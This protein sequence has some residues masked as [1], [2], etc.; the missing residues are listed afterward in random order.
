MPSPYI[1]DLFQGMVADGR[2]EP[3]VHYLEMASPDTYW[4]DCALPDYAEVLPG[5]WFGFMGS[6]IHVNPGAARRV[7]A[8]R[9]DVVV[10]AGYAGLTNQAVMARLRLHRQ[11][12]IFW[13]EISGMNRRRRLGQLLRWL[14]RRPAVRWPQGIAAIGSRAADAYRAEATDRCIVANIPYCCNLE[15]FLAIPR[16]TPS[17]AGEVRFLYCGQLVARKGVDLLVPAMLDVAD[18]HE[19]VRLTLVGEGPLREPLADMVAE[20]HRARV[21]FAGFQSI[22]ELPRWFADADVFVLPSRHDGWG[23]V[24]NQAIAAGL[25][26]VASSAVGA[27]A[28]LVVEGRN[29]HVFPCGDRRGLAEALGSLAASPEKRAAFGQCSRRLAAEWTVA[30]MVDRWYRL[31]RD[32]LS[33]GGCR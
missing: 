11:P 1:Q 7:L 24:V 4:G 6:R 19:N 3:Q 15:P 31:C 12:W 8:G 22:A 13:G 16:E 18:C 20:R 14:A 26:V 28:D 33:L 21:H 17:C 23:V 5:H 27:A 9:P 29:G 25:P 2:I 30:R 32:V 10:V